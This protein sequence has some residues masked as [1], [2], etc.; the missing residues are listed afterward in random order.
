MPYANQPTVIVTELSDENFKFAL[1]NTDLRF[2]NSSTSVESGALRPF[3]ESPILYTQPCVK[4][5]RFII[6]AHSFPRQILPNAAAPFAKFRGSPR[7][8]LRRQ[9]LWIPRPPILEYIVPTLAQL[10]TYNF[11]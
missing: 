1:E 2:V 3:W 11:K 9:I 8:I 5:N 6:M 10:Y 7:Q 4:C